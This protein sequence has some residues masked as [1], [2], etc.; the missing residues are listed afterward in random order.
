MVVYYV[1][2]LVHDQVSLT[3][4]ST[5]ESC[6]GPFI[7]TYVGTLVSKLVGLSF[8]GW[9]GLTVCVVHDKVGFK[10]GK[11]TGSKVEG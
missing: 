5:F 8:G 2:V 11:V 10:E 1:N 4:Q 9:V 3:V 6:V 7:Q